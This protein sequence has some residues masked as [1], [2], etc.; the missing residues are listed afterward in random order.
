MRFYG[1]RHA[2]AFGW[3]LYSQV[4]PGYGKPI[5]GGKQ[6][7]TWNSRDGVTPFNWLED[8]KLFVHCNREYDRH[9]PDYQPKPGDRIWRDSTL[10]EARQ[11]A[12]LRLLS[13]VGS[14][15]EIEKGT[16]AYEEKLVAI[17]NDFLKM[18]WLETVMDLD[19]K[20]KRIREIKTILADEFS[21]PSVLKSYYLRLHHELQ[22][23]TKN[24]LA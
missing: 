21:N 7:W 11:H 14:E 18:P 2:E 4:D 22:R 9:E 6:I 20:I 8:G 1:Y 19:M 12:E 10:M 23:L 24:P 16:S 13:F 15:F 3:Q 5:I 17:T